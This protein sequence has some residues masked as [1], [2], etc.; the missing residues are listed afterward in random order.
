MKQTTKQQTTSLRWPV[1]A[2]GG[3]RLG[4]T[5]AT[6]IERES[7]DLCLIRS[8]YPMAGCHPLVDATVPTV[9]TALDQWFLTVSMQFP[10][11]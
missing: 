4:W 8:L 10:I 6:D 9:A 5:H 11:L 3:N 7:I 1:M 2:E